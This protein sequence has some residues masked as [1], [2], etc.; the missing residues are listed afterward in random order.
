VFPPGKTWLEKNASAFFDLVFSG[1]QAARR[2]R[3]VKPVFD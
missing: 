1:R 2:R 3:P